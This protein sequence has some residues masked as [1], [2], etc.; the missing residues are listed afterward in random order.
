[1]RFGAPLTG[2]N[3]QVVLMLL[4]GLRRRPSLFLRC[5]SLL[6]PPFPGLL[7]PSPM[8]FGFVALLFDHLFVFF[9]FFISYI[10]FII[11]MISLSVLCLVP[12]HD[13][14]LGSAWAPCHWFLLLGH[15]GVAFIERRLS[16]LILLIIFC[17]ISYC[18]D[19]TFVGV[20]CC[21]LIYGKYFPFCP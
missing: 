17:V 10:L 9:E 4:T 1:V 3:S 7:S 14:C 18:F 2:L 16:L 15:V 19:D 12:C 6:P 21:F 8:P 5:K 20:P 13:F 11:L